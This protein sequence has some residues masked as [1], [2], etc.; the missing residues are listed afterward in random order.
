MDIEDSLGSE[1]SIDS[2]NVENQN[3]I[4]LG[5]CSH[6]YLFIYFRFRFIQI[7]FSLSLRKKKYN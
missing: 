2:T 1:L 7:S 4:T 5:K 6:F 3:I